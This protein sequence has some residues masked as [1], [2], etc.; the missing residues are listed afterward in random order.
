MSPVSVYRTLLLV[1][2]GSFVGAWVVNWSHWTHP[3]T[4]LVA[5]LLFSAVLLIVLIGLWFFHRWARWA[6][7]LLL[8][9]GVVYAAVRPH[10]SVVSAT[11]LFAVMLNTMIIAGPFLPP[12]RD[13]FAKQDLTKR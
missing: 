12:L 3:Y 6:V 4:S 13:M 10:H 5:S 1:R 8:A 11:M 9:P 7:V 2:G